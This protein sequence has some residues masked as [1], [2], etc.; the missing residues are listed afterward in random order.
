MKLS[1]TLKHAMVT[2]L[3]SISFCASADAPVTR[4]ILISNVAVYDGRGDTLKNGLNVLIEGNL[5]KKIGRGLIADESAV[6]IDGGGRT[7]MPGLHD[8]HTHVSIFRE[9]SE[10]R[11]NMSPLAHGALAAAR[12]E[13]MLM[14]GFT[15]IMDVGGP[16]AYLRPL[17]DEGVLV[18]PRIYSA[19]AL[20]SQTSGHGDFRARNDL[21]PNIDGGPTNWYER[22]TSCIADTPGEVTRCARENFRNG[23]THL[24]LMTSGGV[25]SRFDPLHSLQGSPAEVRAAVEAAK[26]WK[27]F[28]SVHAYTD[29]AVKMSLENG[30]KY[31]LH[32][33]QVTEET[34]KLMA[35]QGAYVNVNLEAVLGLEEELAAQMLS[36]E[37]FRKWKSLVDAY[38]VAMR[39]MVKHKVK[40]V[41]GTD[42]LAPWNKSVAYDDSAA[43]DLLQWVKFVSAADALRGITSRSGEVAQMTGP[44][45]PYPDG[46]TEVIEQG[47]YAD[48]LVIDGNPLED[49]S[50]MTDPDQNFRIIMK[51]GIVYKNTL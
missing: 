1:H 15:T 23:A 33:P 46:P 22:H 39:T 13:G 7:L 35:K 17:I 16:A 41:F 28:V 25:S 14:N 47:A 3:V 32:A 49:I 11:Q 30:V 4:Q 31:I 34:A 26:N 20:I 36:P 43:R 8:M 50:I 18:G 38:P 40:L 12:V 45:N 9:I 29:E 6:I 2:C 51:D 44:N 19:E 21:H 37:S 10:A 5:I 27:T 24:K 42:L 48:L